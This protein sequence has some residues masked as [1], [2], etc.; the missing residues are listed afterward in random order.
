MN[1]IFEGSVTNNLKDENTSVTV[2]R[3]KED[4]GERLLEP[5]Y[6]SNTQ[7]F[8]RQESWQKSITITVAVNKPIDDKKTC[9]V[10]KT[11]GGTCNGPTKIGNFKW[12]IEMISNKESHSDPNAT[13]EIEVS[14]KE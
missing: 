5:F 9:T 11:E 8:P 1:H 3:K 14:E 10:T 4:Q 7:Q 12:E 6:P 2:F 13:V